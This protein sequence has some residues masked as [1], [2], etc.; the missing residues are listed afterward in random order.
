MTLAD[1]TSL[2]HYVGPLNRLLAPADVTE[3]CVN[4]PGEVWVEAR[5]GWRRVAAAWATF[6]W[7]AH[8]ARL[9]AASSQQR[10][11]SQHPLLSA[12]MPGGERVQVVAP[13]A[14]QAGLVALAIRK[15]ACGERSLASLLD[16]GFADGCE[17]ARVSAA[18]DTPLH[19]AFCAHRWGD[20]LREAVRTRRNILVSGPTGA[21]KTTLTRALIGE[22]DPVERLVT[23]EDAPE[24]ALRADANAVRLYYSKDEQGVSRLTPR[25]LLEACLRLRPERIL[26]AELRGAEAYQYLR[27]VNSGHPGSITSIHASS[28]LLAFEQLALLVKESDAGRDMPRDDIHALLRQVVDV[29][30]HCERSGGRRH[31]REIWWRDA[32]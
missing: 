21:G 30:V 27:A 7:A 19:A 25:H 2:D 3:V 23:I 26:L 15:N 4:R 6:E 29:V 28:C 22:I 13:P 17:V 32:P 14:T 10:L 8:L 11:N 9:L 31:I 1:A 5:G 24:L 18:A 20:F 16:G 12:S